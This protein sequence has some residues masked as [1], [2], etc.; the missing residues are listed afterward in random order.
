[1]DSLIL[2]QGTLRCA[3]DSVKCICSTASTEMSAYEIIF[4]FTNVICTIT[5]IVLAIYIFRQGNIRD[6]AK[7][8][9]QRKMNMFQ[10]LVLNYNIN[11][12]YGFYS[13]L[14]SV[15]NGLLKQGLTIE[16]KQQINDQIISNIGT[17]FRVEF[18]D[19]LNA[20][21]PSLYESIM[22]EYDTLVDSITNHIFDEGI[23]L[24]HKPKF[25]E[26]ITSNIFKAKTEMLKL[27]FGY[28]GA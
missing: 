4:N 17:K 10:A 9:K 5:N 13:D 14:I 22:A 19:C 2:H 26:L 7:T 20:I 21:N 16:E 6:D 1:M 11:Y 27:L 23:N 12:F 18:V 3:V 15:A 8:E 25:D 28:D 24:S